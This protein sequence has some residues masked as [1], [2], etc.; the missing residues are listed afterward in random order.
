MLAP[1][2]SII[3]VDDESHI[4]DDLDPPYCA[5]PLYSTCQSRTVP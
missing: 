4:S 5:R 2:D 3:N 1:N